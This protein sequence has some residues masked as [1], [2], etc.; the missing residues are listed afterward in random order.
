M[1]IPLTFGN[2]SD[3]TRNVRA[4]GQCSL[5]L[6]GKVYQAVAPA[7]HRRR[8]RRAADPRRIRSRATT[9]VQAARN[10][11]VHAA[12]AGHPLTERQCHAN[13]SHHRP[14][15]V[16]PA[17]GMAVADLLDSIT[18]PAASPSPISVRA[19]RCCSSMSAPWSF[20][21]RDVIA[22]G[23]RTTSVVWRLTPPGCGLSYRSESAATLAHAADAV[24][25]VVDHA[26]AERCHAGRARPRRS[27]RLPHRQP[28]RRPLRGARLRQLLRLAAQR[29]RVPRH[30]HPHGQ[31]T[32]ARIRREARMASTSHLNH[33]SA[34]AVTGAEP[35]WRSFRAGIDPCGAAR[36]A[37]LL[38]QTP[39]TPTTSTQS[40]MPGCAPTRR[41][42][43]ADDL[44]SVQ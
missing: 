25:A 39:A 3:W 30:A 24:T 26:A 4:A 12:A 37:R 8:A 5:R 38:P 31:R 15:H 7:I 28:A 23:C 1:L 13:S 21:W 16:A 41:S 22:C 36:V 6:N 29:A 27:G 33:V 32:G 10:S 43:A 9:S 42:A 18:A 11:A 20:V 17:S 34:S 44:R 40:S 19:R 35:I 2:R 14:A